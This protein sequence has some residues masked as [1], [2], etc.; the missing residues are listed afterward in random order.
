[1]STKNKD[2]AALKRVLKKLLAQHG[3]TANALANKLNV[4]TP[5]IH[6]LVTGDVKDPRI[7]TL[8][9]IANYFSVTIEQL[10][11]REKM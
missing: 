8:I 7:S 2:A 3:L 1:M 6:R 11:G 9:I 5:T 4:P 10:L